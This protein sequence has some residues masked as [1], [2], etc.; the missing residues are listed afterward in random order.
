M[1]DHGNP[2]PDHLC[3]PRVVSHIVKGK[4]FKS[5]FSGSCRGTQKRLHTKTTGVGIG[6]RCAVALYLCEW[7]GSPG[8]LA[9]VFN[10]VAY[11]DGIATGFKSKSF[12]DDDRVNGFEQKRDFQRCVWGHFIAAFRNREQSTGL[13]VNAVRAN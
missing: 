13:G 5:I 8:V 3:L 1:L 12:G 10:I 7:N 4:L 2:T 11:I 9:V 6:W